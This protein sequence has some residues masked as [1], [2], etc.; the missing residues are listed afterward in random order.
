L[1]VSGSL[2]AIAEHPSNDPPVSPISLRQL[3][4]RMSSNGISAEVDIARIS[5]IA[6]GTCFSSVG[7]NLVA[8]AR[9]V[10]HSIGGSK[11]VNNDR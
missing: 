2:N 5:S 9:A 6:E 7:R 1:P 3:R 8:M 10:D 11:L 4:T